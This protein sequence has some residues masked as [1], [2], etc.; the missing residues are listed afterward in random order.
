MKKFLKFIIAALLLMIPLSIFAQDVPTDPTGFDIMSLFTSFAGYAAGVLVI[1]GVIC[2]YILKNLSTLGRSI[3]SWVVAA[4]VALVGYFLKLGIF[5]D[6]DWLKLIVIVLSFA[7]G[8]N[9]IYNVEWIRA[10]LAMLKI[11]PAKST[12]K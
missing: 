4:L 2:R 12:T 7:A 11:L 6:L 3:T 8:S 5:V 9:V 10:L 1:T